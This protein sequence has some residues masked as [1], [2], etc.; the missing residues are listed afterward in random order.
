MAYHHHVHL[1]IF[2]DG[3]PYSVPLGIGFVPP[4]QVTQS[5]Q[6]AFAEGSPTCLYW[7]HVH[8]A[9]G[10]VHIE[11]PE[12]RTFQLGQLM[13]IWHVPISATQLGTYTGNV[14]AT[15]NGVP[16]TGELRQIP[17]DEHAQI[18]LNVGGPVVTPPPISWSGT[19]L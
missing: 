4:A 17:L 9:D 5:P 16:W 11:S 12:V 15:L 1:A 2:V 18:V 6:G 7:L 14:T 3:K 10:I 13:D 19:G 8:A